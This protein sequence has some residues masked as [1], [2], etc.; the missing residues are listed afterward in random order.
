MLTTEKIQYHI[1]F[2][3]EKHDTLDEQ[4]IKMESQRASDIEIHALK[5]EKLHILDE[6]V[7]LEK[8]LK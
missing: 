7:E 2:L 4:I 3:Q 5:K 6:I 1:A 8:K